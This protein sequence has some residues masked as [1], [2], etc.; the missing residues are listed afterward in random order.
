MTNYNDFSPF[1]VVGPTLE[2]IRYLLF[3]TSYPG[4]LWNTVLISTAATFLSLFAAV[5]AAYAIERLR[6]SGSRQVG[7]GDLPR[8][9]GAALDPLHPAR[10]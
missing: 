3:E 6:F 4:W 2:H 8:L 7:L 5:F 1:W 10:R 9:S